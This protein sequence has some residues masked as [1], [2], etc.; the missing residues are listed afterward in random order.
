MKRVIIDPLAVTHIRDRD[1]GLSPHEH[2]RRILSHVD[3][4]YRKLSD[5]HIVIVSDGETP[6]EEAPHA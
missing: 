1:M 6:Y 3:H 5:V 4:L 2:A